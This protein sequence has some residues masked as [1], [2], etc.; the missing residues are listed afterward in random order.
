VKALGK[1][2]LLPPPSPPHHLHIMVVMEGLNASGMGYIIRNYLEKQ[3]GPE[4]GE[5]IDK[6][7][8]WTVSMSKVH[9]L[10]L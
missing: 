1:Y 2:K 4:G 3:R 7:G 8:Q 10:C 6:R 9:Y 5:R